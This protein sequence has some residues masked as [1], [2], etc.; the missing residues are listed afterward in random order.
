MYI[1]EAADISALLEAG[2]AV[3]IANKGGVTPLI[4][5][6]SEGWSDDYYQPSGSQEYWDSNYPDA[7]SAYEPDYYSYAQKGKG[8]GF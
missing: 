7:H 5:A 2:A 1:P 3:N 8:Q 4:Y 6:A